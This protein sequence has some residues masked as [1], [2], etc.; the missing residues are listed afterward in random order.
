MLKAQRQK[1]CHQ[2]VSQTVTKMKMFS[3][4][5]AISAQY[6]A[7]VSPRGG[8]GVVTSYI[9]PKGLLFQRCQVYNWPIFLQQKVYDWPIFLD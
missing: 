2:T 7:E 5:C 9:W 1:E 8:S 6:L 4:L 3:L